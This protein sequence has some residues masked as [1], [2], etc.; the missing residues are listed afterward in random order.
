MHTDHTRAAFEFSRWPGSG[1]GGGGSGPGRTGEPWARGFC[2]WVLGAAPCG[3]TSPAQGRPPRSCLAIWKGVCESGADVQLPCWG[4]LLSQWDSPS[5][6]LP[7]LVRPAGRARGWPPG[8][9]PGR[10]PHGDIPRRCAHVCTWQCA[11]AESPGTTPLCLCLRLWSQAGPAR[12]EDRRHH[13][14]LH[15][16]ART[17]AGHSASSGMSDF[18]AALFTLQGSNS[19]FHGRAGLI[20]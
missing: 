14:G 9:A 5:A 15:G 7:G 19:G 17:H 18:P 13:R 11:T 8:W 4:S 16:S 12:P 2:R 3:K 20:P 6:V 10:T 1:A